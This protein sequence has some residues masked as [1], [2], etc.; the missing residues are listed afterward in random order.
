MQL[1]KKLLLL[2]LPVSVI[3]SCKHELPTDGNT[4]PS[5]TTSNIDNGVPCDS[6]TVY[7]ANSI[8]PALTQYCAMSGCHNAG[9]AANG[10]RLTDY[11]SIMS[12]ADVRPGNP[13]GSDLYEVLV[14]SDPDKRMPPAGSTPMPDS[15]INLIN[16]W[17]QQGAKNN[18][19]TPSCDTT[20]FGYQ[21]VISRIIGSN[22][23]GCHSGNNPSG[24]ILLN[25]YDNVKAQCV[26]N[27]LN[28]AIGWTTTKRI[29]PSAKMSDC[30]IN[31]ISKWKSNN[32][33]Q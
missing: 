11:N 19:C 1:R 14:T 29:P 17:I 5:D 30:N 21:S 7:F 25:S 23:L 22:C 33:P 9:T 12:T 6:D 24:G 10:V 28:T 20:L 4:N 16:L 8:L 3:F 27:K 32:Y 15:L 2:I 18:A 26:N 13:G 31:L